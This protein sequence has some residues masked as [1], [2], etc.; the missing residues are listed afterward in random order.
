[1]TI[2]SMPATRKRSENS[3]VIEVESN[4][5][6]ISPI[7]EVL[8]DNEQSLAV[9]G[10]ITPSVKELTNNSLLNDSELKPSVGGVSS[11]VYNPNSSQYG[12]FSQDRN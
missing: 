11:S 4:N 7:P 8:H 6:A 10:P 2:I 3:P 5:G 9:N 1:M 12:D